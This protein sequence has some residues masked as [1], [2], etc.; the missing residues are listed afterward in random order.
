MAS[1][2]SL[3]RL[4]IVCIDPFLCFAAGMMLNHDR[5]RWLSQVCDVMT[6]PSADAFLPTVMTVHSS[7]RSSPEPVPVL[8][9]N[10]YD[11]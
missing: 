7:T 1:E 8:S 2:S 9:A 3:T 6:D 10:V 4:Y 11:H 5:V